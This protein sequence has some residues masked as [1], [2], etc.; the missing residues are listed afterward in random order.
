MNKLVIVIALVIAAANA[1][2]RSTGRAPSVEPLSQIRPTER[3]MLTF[4]LDD[5]TGEFPYEDSEGQLRSE[6][7]QFITYSGPSGRV[8]DISIAL[9]GSTFAGVRHCGLVRG[10][11]EPWPAYLGCEIRG[12]SAFGGWSGSSGAMDDGEF[13]VVTKLKPT[14]R[15]RIEFLRNGDELSVTQSC[16]SVG[17]WFICRMTRPSGGTVNSAE[18]T[19]HVQY[20]ISSD[21]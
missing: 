17:G 4:P 16:G 13:S 11:D 2:C 3:V 6:R 21:Q 7:S 12:G 1:G 14:P 18:L 8:L 15:Y 20:V 5:V 19:V 10:S 9:E